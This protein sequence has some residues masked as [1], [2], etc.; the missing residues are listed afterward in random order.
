MCIPDR[1]KIL[2]MWYWNKM[3]EMGFSFI[4]VFIYSYFQNTS[5]LISQFYYL[6]RNIPMWLSQKC[7][8][9]H[10]QKTFIAIS[11]QRDNFYY[12]TALSVLICSLIKWNTTDFLSCSVPTHPQSVMQNV[13][14]SID[15]PAFHVF[16]FSAVSWQSHRAVPAGGLVQAAGR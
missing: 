13:L 3:E 11:V 2:Q 1:Q 8:Q 4:Y 5:K 7:H 12:T 10:W 16:C 15:L 9:Q 6:W 14:H